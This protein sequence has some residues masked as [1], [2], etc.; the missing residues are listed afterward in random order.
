MEHQHDDIIRFVA[1]QRPRALTAEERLD[2]LYLHALFRKQGII[3]VA[4]HI[5]GILGR[6]IS[7]VWAQYTAN[8]AVIAAASVPDT[9]VVLE[10]VQALLRE[11]RII[12]ARVMAKDEMVLRAQAA[13]INIDTG[14]DRD[15]AACL[16]VVQTYSI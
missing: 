9:K 7:Q 1:K 8:E 5:A 2:I 6:G 11:R 15:T 16:R 14:N 3:G 13:H 4:Q 12:K 10:L